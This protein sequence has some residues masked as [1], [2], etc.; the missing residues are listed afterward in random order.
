LLGTVLACRLARSCTNGERVS[1]SERCT[2]PLSVGFLHPRVILP[3]QSRHWSPALLDSVLA[4]E[5]EHVRRRDPLIEWLAMLVRCAYWFHPLAWWLRRKLAA[6]AEEA[7]DEAVLHRGHDPETYAELLVELARS[8]KKGGAMVTAWGSPINGSGLAMRIRRILTAGQSPA[9]SHTRT[10][11]VTVLCAVAIL[12]PVLFNLEYAGAALA[13]APRGMAPA[14]DSSTRLD[15]TSDRQKV[16]PEPDKLTVRRITFVGPRNS[17]EDRDLRSACSSVK[18]GKSYRPDALEK[19]IAAVNK[20]AIY[21]EIGKA[22]CLVTLSEGVPLALDIEIRLTPKGSEP[23][24]LTPVDP[25]RNW[26]TLSAANPKAPDAQMKIIRIF[27]RQMNDSDRD[28]KVAERALAEIDK[29]LALFPDSDYAPIASQWKDAVSRE[30]AQAPPKIAGCVYDPA[31]DPVAGVE[32]QVANSETKEVLAASISD[33]KGCFEFRTVQPKHRIELRL[34]KPGFNTLSY[35]GDTLPDGSIKI[36]M[37]LGPPD[38]AQIRIRYAQM[39]YKVADYYYSRGNY[40]AA[41]SRYQEAIGY[42][43][44]LVAAHNGLGRSYEARGENEKALAVYKEFLDKF[45]GSP[46]APEFKS[47]I[48]GL[49]KKQPS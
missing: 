13:V 11:V 38:T 4:H 36:T 41:I 30:L 19:C 46:I 48:A 15:T 24:N 12:L 2:V 1:R 5:L 40:L 29:F 3:V 34:A 42:Q 44:D 47:R 6:L 49:E 18:E 23:T 20:L 35:S 7:C 45:P 16:S 21:K 27:M 39:S 14:S 32:I 17:A 37:Q 8:V 28:W 22:D 9:L 26:A 10:T 25:Y 43:P 33:E 31:G